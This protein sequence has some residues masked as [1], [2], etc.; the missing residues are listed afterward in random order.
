[1]KLFFDLNMNGINDIKLISSPIHMFSQFVDLIT[2]IVLIK[3][4]D[5]KNIFLDVFVIKKK[6]DCFYI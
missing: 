6:K 1:M 4:L 2:I 3:I 5:K